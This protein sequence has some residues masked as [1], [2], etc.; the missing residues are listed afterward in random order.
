MKQVDLYW[1]V[2][3]GQIVQAMHMNTNASFYKYSYVDIHNSIITC[4]T[5]YYFIP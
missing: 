5:A 1:K 4:L 3:F 2:N